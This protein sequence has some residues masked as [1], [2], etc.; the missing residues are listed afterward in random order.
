[1]VSKIDENVVRGACTFVPLAQ[2]VEFVR[3]AAEHCMEGV[4]ITV[5]GA[6]HGLPPMYKEAP[7]VRQ[8]YLMG[9]LWK[10]YF[11]LDFD[12]VEG[13]PYLMA[14][15]DYDR[16][17][18]THP[19]NALQ[20]MKAV[21]EVRDICFDILQDYGELVVMLEREVAGLSKI[22]NDGVTRALA[23]MSE[24]VSAQM[25]DEAKQEMRAQ[26]ERIV[27]ERRPKNDG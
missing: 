13:D 6:L 23:F 16:A 3:H 24:Q 2:K 21:P 9:A 17:A 20:K 11:L 18:S 14:A 15:D 19:L 25:L 22:H 10:L 8:R 4:E 7:A 5:E 12:P 27:E 1:M 26:L